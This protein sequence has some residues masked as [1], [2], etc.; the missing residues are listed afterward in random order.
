MPG[1]NDSNKKIFSNPITNY[2]FIVV[3]NLQLFSRHFTLTL[4]SFSLCQHAKRAY[5]FFLLANSRF[6][7]YAKKRI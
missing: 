6:K 4:K 5:Y 7:A 3:E 2:I 1:E